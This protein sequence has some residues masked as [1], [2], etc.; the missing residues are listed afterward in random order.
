MR[1]YERALKCSYHHSLFAV[2]NLRF[3]SGSLAARG[4]TLSKDEQIYLNEAFE[5]IANVQ[6][7][8]EAV[9]PKEML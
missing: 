1:K 5:S 3:L 7:Q 8:I 2:D 9:V 6:E 4:V